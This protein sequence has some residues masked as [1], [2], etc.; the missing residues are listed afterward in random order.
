[1]VLGVAGTDSSGCAGIAADLRTVAA[2]GGH[3]LLAVTAVT[4]QGARGV[5]ALYPLPPAT[6]SAQMVAALDIP[7][8]RAVKIGMLANAAVVRA[9]CAVIEQRRPP[10][11]VLDPVL[12]ATSG[13]EL[14]DAP[15]RAERHE[16]PIGGELLHAAADRGQHAWCGSV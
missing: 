16:I 3:G 5:R 8:C 6:I 9:V 4:A 2:L 10:H 7:G 13:G 12:K 15:L 1:M 11:L 14:L